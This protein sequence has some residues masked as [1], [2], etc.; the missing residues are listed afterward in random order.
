ML[1]DKL[2]DPVSGLTHLGAAILSF[3]GLIA[4]ILISWGEPAKLASMIVYGTSLIVMFSASATYHM[5][6]SSPKVIEILRK[7]D[8]SAIFLL[9]AGTYT[10]FCINA[11][12]GFWKWGLFSIIWALAIIG[13]GIKIFIVR[14]PRWVNAGVYLI[15]GWLVIA[16]TGE[17]LDKLPI[18]AL[19]W[20]IAG[21]LIYTLGA[22]IYITKTL[23]FKPWVFGFHEVWHIFVILAAVAHFISILVYIAV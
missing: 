16:A 4:L 6:I 12:S 1:K 11:F 23:D 9:I 21:G 20:L 19:I 13:V 3:F 15:M 17:M 18:G 14:A 10:P 8:H 5:T 7:V 22:I 2:R